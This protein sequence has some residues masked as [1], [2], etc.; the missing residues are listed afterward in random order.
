MASTAGRRTRR[1][2][3]QRASRAGAGATQVL[4]EL[5]PEVEREG[6]RTPVPGLR[7]QDSARSRSLGPRARPLQGLAVPRHT[8]GRA[9]GEQGQRAGPGAQ[10]AQEGSP[11]QRLGPLRA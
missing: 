9:W 4:P 6:E 8:R 11:P 2:W 10:G 5:R 1:L 3:N 7:W